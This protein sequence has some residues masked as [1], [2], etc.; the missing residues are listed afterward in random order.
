[1]KD[2]WLYDRLSRSTNARYSGKVATV[3]LICGALPVGVVARGLLEPGATTGHATV[4]VIVSALAS[5]LCAMVVRALETP[6]GAPGRRGTSNAVSDVVTG[7]PDRASFVR[8]LEAHAQRPDASGRGYAV[9]VI[10]VCNLDMAAASLSPSEVRRVLRTQARRLDALCGGPLPVAR[11]RDDTFAFAVG[12]HDTAKG[13]LDDASAAVHALSKEISLEVGA[14]SPRVA[15]GI[16]LVPEDA[17]EAEG[18]VDKALAALAVSV[19]HGN[20]QVLLYSHSTHAR[21]RHA[22]DLER[23]LREAVVDRRLDLVFQPIVEADSGR[24]LGSE[25]LVRW[26]HPVHGDVP[27]STFIP[28]AERCGLVAAI[29]RFVLEEAGKR[30]MA[31]RSKLAMPDLFVSVN[32]SAT[33][34]R[35]THLAGWIAG[36]LRASFIDPSAVILEVTETATLHDIDHGSSVVGQLRELGVRVAL[37]DFGTGHSWLSYLSRIDVDRIKIDQA[38]VR[39]VHENPRHRAICEA[40]AALARGLSV[41]VVAE[42]VERE[43]HALCLRDLG[44]HHLQGYYFAGPLT[45]DRFAAY[46]RESC[47]RAARPPK[48]RSGGRSLVPLGTS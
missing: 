6:F 2:T 11:V 48:V 17:A 26:R 34:F 36:L 47:E 9:C 32:L 44:I 38:F 12:A 28:L 43:E 41:R 27:P 23:A 31:W 4:L 3:V 29:D 35:D 46:A 18:A 33:Q 15:A 8:S 45:P 39:D 20:R 14:F 37:D 10:R 1:M 40:I 30:T 19:Q 25:A 21:V 5:A 16:A 42:G 24:T 7:L 13:A 22:L